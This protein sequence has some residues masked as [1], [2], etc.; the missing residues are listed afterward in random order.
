MIVKS[1]GGL[2]PVPILISP[3]SGVGPEANC[4][5]LF[6]CWF[7]LLFG[8]VSRFLVFRRLLAFLCREPRNPS[9]KIGTQCRLAYRSTLQHFS[10]NT[11]DVTTFTVY[12]FHRRAPCFF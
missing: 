5:S 4:L 3:S 9:I 10:V 12:F 7:L 11:M 6:L 2:T 1:C 8:R